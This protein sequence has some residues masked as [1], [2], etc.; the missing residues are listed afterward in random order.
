MTKQ[1]KLQELIDSLMRDE[2]KDEYFLEYVPGQGWYLSPCTRKSFND[3]GEFLGDSYDSAI[4]YI[5]SRE[6]Y[7]IYG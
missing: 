3:T 4:Q 7:S 2:I 5:E 1:Q 6:F